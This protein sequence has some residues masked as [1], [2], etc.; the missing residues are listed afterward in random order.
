MSAR[1][2]VVLTTSANPTPAASSTAPRLRSVR[3]V[4]SSTVP[5]RSSPR[6][7]VD[8]PLARAEDEVAGDDRLAVRPDGGRRAGGRDRL[9]GHGGAP[10]CPGRGWSSAM[11]DGGPSPMRRD[12]AVGDGRLDDRRRRPSASRQRRIERPEGRPGAGQPDRPAED[13]RQRPP[14]LHEAR[15]RPAPRPRSR[16]LA[17]ARTPARG[18]EVRGGQPVAELLGEVRDVIRTEPSPRRRACAPSN[19]ANTS[20]VRTATAGVTS[21]IARAGRA[22]PAAA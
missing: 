12:R 8:R 20:G 19:T 1:K 2:T 18:D 9:S 14:E 4:S 21:R 11:I 22:S 17:D 10:S 7:G 6:R 16:S 3:S 5:W 13:A 15:A